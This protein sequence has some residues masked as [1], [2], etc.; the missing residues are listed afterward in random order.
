MLEIE[1]GKMLLDLDY[2]LEKEYFD[3]EVN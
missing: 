1:I 2:G 3:I